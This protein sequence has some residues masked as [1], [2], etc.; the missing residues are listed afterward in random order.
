MSDFIKNSSF[1]HKIKIV[2]MG[3]GEFALPTLY[4]L[5]E[6]NSKIDICEI[7]TAIPGK[8]EIGNKIGNKIGNNKFSLE[9][10][11]NLNQTI[12]SV[13]EFGIANNINIKTPLRITEDVINHIRSI[14]PDLI[15]VVSYG[16]ILPE[17]LLSV[18]KYYCINL[19]PSSLPRWRGAAPIQ[20]AIMAGDNMT[21]ICVMIMDKGCD[22]GPVI[23]RENYNLDNTKVFGEISKDIAEIGA[24]MMLSVIEDIILYNGIIL[25][26]IQ[27]NEG[28][29]Y[30]SK[31]T[32][33]DEVINF[34]ESGRNIHYKIK[35]LSPNP[36]AYC[37]F[38]N[39]R[40][41]LLRSHY[42]SLKENNNI[43][44]NQNNL[45]FLD[46]TSLNNIFFDFLI[47][48]ENQHNIK[49][50]QKKDD[51]KIIQ[52]NLVL[53]API[54][55]HNNR[56]FIICSSD[57]DI[58]LNYYNNNYFSNIFSNMFNFFSLKTK[59]RGLLCCAFGEIIEIIELQIEGGKILSATQ[60]INGYLKSKK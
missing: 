6:N 32:K 22:T 1:Y 28:S 15:V 58:N 57:D 37:L 40:L 14:C 7:Y 20:R 46:E 55:S 27:S 42:F 47:S 12:S 19:H 56:I 8:K 39:K 49:I 43:N 50:D 17:N 13:Y 53:S 41:K 30:A 36:G 54:F 38:R 35:A 9:Q 16:L 26:S 59:E 25:S 3:T 45:F 11:K 31:I 33:D 48:A 44:F 52:D 60:F 51:N 21:D 23:K 2:F 34:K 29:C 10:K 4:T 18:P 5:L 24:K